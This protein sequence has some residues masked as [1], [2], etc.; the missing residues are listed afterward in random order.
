MH[1][2]KVSFLFPCQ[3][4]WPTL[5]LGPYEDV[6]FNSPSQC[7]WHHGE[8]DLVLPG[9]LRDTNMDQ[10]VSS[11]LLV[12]P[13]YLFENPSFS[14]P[15]HRFPQLTPVSESVPRENVATEDE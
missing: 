6:S 9:N 12:T 2:W 5:A 14:F 11:A 7:D 10:R 15:A 1:L 3:Q 13:V 4:A 8:V